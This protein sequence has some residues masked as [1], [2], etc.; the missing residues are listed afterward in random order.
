MA[1]G[2]LAFHGLGLYRE[3]VRTASR[4]NATAY[5][6]SI[7]VTSSFGVVY[8]LEPDPGLWAYFAFAAGAALGFPLVVGV[9]TKGWR[10]VTF[11]AER[12]EVLIF[13]SA[14]NVASVLGGVGAAALVAWAAGQWAAWTFAPL[15]A[16]CVYLAAQGIEYA[17]AEEEERR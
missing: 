16:T 6:Y 17:V 10:E 13:A 15:A 2:G 11:D 5:G 7:M 8:S 4:E 12:T 1:R 3:G 9:A 14:I